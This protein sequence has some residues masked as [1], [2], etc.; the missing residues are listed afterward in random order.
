MS[1]AMDIR[2]NYSNPF[3]PSTTINFFIPKQSY[4]TLSVYDIT[5]QKVATLVDKH[6][7]AGKHSVI[8][9]GSDFGSG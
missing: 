8:F 4:V 9:D 2:G 3:N 1:T 7:I 6:I 5:G